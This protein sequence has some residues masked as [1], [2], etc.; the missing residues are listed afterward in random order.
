MAVTEL[1][2][3]AGFTD[4]LRYVAVAHETPVQRQFPTRGM[5]SQYP[6]GLS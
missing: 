1:L 3:V 6:L 4:D 5:T 2:K